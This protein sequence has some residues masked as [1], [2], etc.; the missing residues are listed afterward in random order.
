M[1]GY[2]IILM[3]H[4]V[5]D[6]DGTVYTSLVVFIIAIN[7]TTIDYT[8]KGTSEYWS[9]VSEIV[10]VFKKWGTVT[11]DVPNEHFNSRMIE[12]LLTDTMQVV[13]CCTVAKFTEDEQCDIRKCAKL[14]ENYLNVL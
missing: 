10:E 8:N 2:I 12:F 14:L 11:V 6:S 1:S 7:I 3:K 4:L 5:V 13:W 9:V